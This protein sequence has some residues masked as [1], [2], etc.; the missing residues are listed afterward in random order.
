MRP[1]AYGDASKNSR[2]PRLRLRHRTKH[3]QHRHH[4][5]YRRRQDHRHRAHP[6]LHGKTYKI[7]EVHE[8]AATMDW[9][10][11]EQ[12]RGITITAAATTCFWNDHRINI[13]DTPGHVDFTVEVE[14]CLR[15]LDGARRRLRRRRRRRAPVR[16]RLAPGRPL[17]RAAHLLHQQARPHRRRLLA[18]RRHDRRAPG[19]NAVPIQIPIG[20]RGRL[21]RASIDLIEMKAGLLQRRPGRPR[22]SRATIPRRA[23]PRPRSS[24]RDA[25]RERR[26]DRTRS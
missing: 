9:M 24:A 2:A 18:R 1:A 6:L 10:E 4:R 19:A 15:V 8:G 25:D 23:A 26:R 21:Q 11:Q 7:G 17:R 12:E 5:P 13:I 16:D 22:S 20:R 14:R 3:P